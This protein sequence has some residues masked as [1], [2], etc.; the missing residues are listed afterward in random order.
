M[1]ILFF[2][3]ITLMPSVPPNLRVQMFLWMILSVFIYCWPTVVKGGLKAP[4]LIATTP[5]C[6]R[7]CYSFPWIT[8]YHRMLSVK[9]EGIKY[10]FFKLSHS[11][12]YQVLNKGKWSNSGK[13]VMPFPKPLCSSYWKGRLQAALDY[14]WSTTRV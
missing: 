11:K 4:F 8:P 5:W 2:I 9:Q 6:R 1:P 7:G 10:H 3:P 14:A 13:G 12:H